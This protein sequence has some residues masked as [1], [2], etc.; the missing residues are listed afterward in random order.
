M[1]AHQ[2]MTAEDYLVQSEPAMR[3]LFDGIVACNE[4]CPLHWPSEAR[5]AEEHAQA[6]CELETWMAGS[7]AR[8]I[9]CGAILEISS[10]AIQAC[11][12][13]SSI[14]AMCKPF[15]DPKKH[16]VF[17]VGRLIHGL[18]LGVLI[19]AGRH[20]YVHWIEE[21]ERDETGAGFHRFV[22]GVFD[23][24][25]RAHENNPFMDLAYGLG[26]TFYQGDAIRAD[27][28]IQ[29]EIGWTNYERHL[30]DMREMLLPPAPDESKGG[31]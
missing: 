28:I 31:A 1:L 19:L 9:L 25:Q 6:M 15:T 4:K 23:V 14:P 3:H 10:Q 21:R 8:S 29:S 11:S 18:P 27:F 20:Q 2:R 24:L 17:C 5:T 13:N 30:A 16:A 12:Q 7:F 22:Q 26:N